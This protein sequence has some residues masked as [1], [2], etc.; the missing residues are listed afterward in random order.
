MAAMAMMPSTA[1]KEMTFFRE[2]VELTSFI[3]QQHIHNAG[4]VAKASLLCQV[5]TSS[6]ISKLVLI[7]FP[8]AQELSL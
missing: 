2:V 4:Q 3:L 6:K 5:M 7:N 1:E 8:A